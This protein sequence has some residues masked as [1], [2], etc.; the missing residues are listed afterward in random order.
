LFF[1]HRKLEEIISQIGEAVQAATK[2]Q[3]NVTKIL[4]VRTAN[5]VTIATDGV[6]P[7]VQI[8][9]RIYS[10]PA[11]VLMGFDIDR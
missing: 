3:S 9:L 4:V 10:S 5:A 7:L 6:R 8:V 1:H 2:Y 11:E